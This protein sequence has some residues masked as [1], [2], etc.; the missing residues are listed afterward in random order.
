M[1]KRFLNAVLV[2]VIGVPDIIEMMPI[3]PSHLATRT[4]EEITQ[5]FAIFLTSD[6]LAKKY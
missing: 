3:L 4:R 2:K 6:A 5:I 1:G